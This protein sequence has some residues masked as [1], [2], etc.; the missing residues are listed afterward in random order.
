[1]QR[2]VER[3]DG[4]IAVQSEPGKGTIVS[5]WLPIVR[6]E[7]DG[8]L[9][10]ASSQVNERSTG[11][12]V[13]K[14]PA[15]PADETR[16]I[17]VVDDDQD[18]ADSLSHLLTLEGYQVVRAYSLP[19]ALAAIDEVPLEVALVDI[20]M[21]ERSGLSL[22]ADLRRRHPKVVCIMMTAYAS[23]QTAIEALQEGA[24]DY[25]CKPFFSED[26]MATLER[27]YERIALTRSR[28]QAEA[29]LR[30]RNRELEDINARLRTVVSSLQGLSTCSTLRE[31]CLTALD[32]VSRNLGGRRTA[33]YLSEGAQTF[34]Q[35]GFALGVDKASEGALLRQLQEA[36]NT[37]SSP[38]TPDGVAALNGV[39]GFPLIGEDGE[40]LGVLAIA[41]SG[42]HAF[43]EQDQELARILASFAS[44]AIRLIHALEVSAIG[45]ERLRKIIDNSPSLIS[46]KDLEGRIL[47]VNKCF[48]EWHGFRQEEVGG[49]RYHEVFPEAIARLYEMQF[50]EVAANRKAAVQEIEIPFSDGSLALGSRG[51]VPRVGGK[52]TGNRHRYHRNRHHRSQAHRRALAANSEDGSPGPADPWDCARLQ[53][54]TSRRVG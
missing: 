15:V 12:V 50:D 53:Q 7:A 1:M 21:G 9:P 48:E 54:Y 31:L 6:Q 14:Q 5:I 22:I 39:I 35:D 20:R 25:L 52:W 4:D 30:R 42:Q 44:E 13:G 23:A 3:H 16:R 46:L 11:G 41:A 51:Q 40:S 17:L 2:I 34:V 47:I 37:S 27:C 32:E 28:E 38:G 29:A 24:Y 33:I 10:T 49:K 19:S 26:L 43:T 8:D 45:E 36:K 18:F